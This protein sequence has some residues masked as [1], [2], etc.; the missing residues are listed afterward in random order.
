MQRISWDPTSTPRLVDDSHC[1]KCPAYMNLCS[2]DLF[3]ES[4]P[5][6]G[7]TAPAESARSCE[8]QVGFSRRSAPPRT[9][10]TP[11]LHRFMHHTFDPAHQG[12]LHVVFP[13]LARR[14]VFERALHVVVAGQLRKT[15]CL[16]DKACTMNRASPVLCLR[17]FE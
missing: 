9:D 11:C 15:Q 4:L 5:S 12:R 6:P 14:Q 16:L 17:T 7:I 2:S 10:P 3:P 1:G 13:R 8:S